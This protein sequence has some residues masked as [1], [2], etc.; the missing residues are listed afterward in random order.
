VNQEGADLGGAQL[1]ETEGL[2][3]ELATRLED[4]VDAGDPV[5]KAMTIGLLGRRSAKGWARRPARGVKRATV[6]RVSYAWPRLGVLRV[7][8]EPATRVR[9]AT[10]ATV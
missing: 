2:P 7:R 9:L 8:C 5:G 3:T 6:R 10:V 1:H 4:V